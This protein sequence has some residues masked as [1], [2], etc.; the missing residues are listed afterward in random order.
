MTQALNLTLYERLGGAPAIEAAVDRFY[1]RIM[2]DPSL[3]HFF[4]RVSMDK[5]REKQ[6]AF[7]TYVFGGPTNYSGKSL[8]I[9]HQ[10]LVEEYGLKDSHFD[11]VVSHLRS[12]LRELK[13][14]PETIKEVV[15]LVETTRND[16]LNR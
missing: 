11:S 16:V 7:M 15:A 9:A 3:A 8:R 2:S 5:Q 6:K 1:D 4:D 12:T 14:A 10:R 13:V